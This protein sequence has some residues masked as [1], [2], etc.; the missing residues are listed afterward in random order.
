MRISN[1]AAVVVITAGLAVVGV[2]TA[3]DGTWIVDASGDWSD[4]ANWDGG[5]IANGADATAY[6]CVPMGI[7]LSVTIDTARTI[8][9]IV[10]CDTFGGGYLFQSA[11]G[12][13]LTLSAPNNQPSFTCASGAIDVEL[14]LVST[15]GFTKLGIGSLYL[16]SDDPCTV[17]GVVDVQGGDLILMNPD[18]LGPD[19]ELV[20]GN[21]SEFHIGRSHTIGSLAGAGSVRLHSGSDLDVGASGLNTEFSGIITSEPGTCWLRKSGSGTL[22]LSGYQHLWWRHHLCGAVR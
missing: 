1:M 10:T 22:T 4:P 2:A 20:V 19:V 6:F 8:G 17:S 15:E 12:G 7:H 3:D 11:S 18:Q 5:I 13:T 21:G 16:G 9:H 14:P